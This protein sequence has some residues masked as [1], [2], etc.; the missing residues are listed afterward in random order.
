VLT[1]V[2]ELRKN[3][4]STFLDQ[5]V[6]GRTSVGD[7]RRQ[8]RSRAGCEPETRIS[9]SYTRI[10]TCCIYAGLRASEADD[11]AQDIWLWLLRQGTPA[12]IVSMPWLSSVARNFI[13]RY[14]RRSSRQKT[15]EGRRL[16][17]APEPRT[18]ETLPELEAS[19]LLDHIA[20]AV[21]E[22]ERRLLALIRRGY[23]LAEASRLLG[24][25][26]GSR[27]YYHKR[28]ITCGRRELHVRTARPASGG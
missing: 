10:L 19:E 27:A 2:E 8:G 11:V 16:D 23:S 4:P 22:I 21:P 24:I 20:A 13:L 25:P 6:V 12:L 1:G 15:R 9:E 5:A 3:R 17:A 26:R 28:L 18:S 7:P 14:R